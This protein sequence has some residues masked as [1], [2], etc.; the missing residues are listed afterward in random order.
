MSLSCVAALLYR[1]MLRENERRG[2]VATA[3]DNAERG[4]I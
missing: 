2:Q 1:V 3:L 4:K